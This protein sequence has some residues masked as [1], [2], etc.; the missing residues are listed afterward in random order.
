MTNH[1][2]AGIEIAV[3]DTSTMAT[4]NTPAL[5]RKGDRDAV[6]HMSHVVR[7]PLWRRPGQ[8]RRRDG[9]LR[10]H[11][12]RCYRTRN[13]RQL[14]TLDACVGPATGPPVCEWLIQPSVGRSGDLRVNGLWR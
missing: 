13:E 12:C 8:G 2:D 1:C 5:K 7:K 14:V 10:G 11:I 4:P 6:P 9:R 3:Q